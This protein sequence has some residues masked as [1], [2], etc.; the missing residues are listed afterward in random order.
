M[1]ADTPPSL[2]APDALS[3]AHSERAAAYIRE[4]IADAGGSIAFAEFMHHALYAPGLGYYAAGTTKFGEGGD[5]VTAPELSKVFGRVLAR[6]C[7]DVLAGI[8]GAAILEYGAGSGK[9]AADMLEALAG[10]NALPAAYL[11]LEVSADL[12]E[13]QEDYLRRRVPDLVHLVTWIDSLPEGHRG[14]I[15]ANEVLDCLPVERFVRRGDSLMQVRVAMNSHG[16]V[17]TEGPAPENLAQ[18][19]ASIERDIGAPL[20]D[21]YMSEVCLAT[22]PWLGG[23]SSALREGVA[24]LF[25][26]GVS[27]REYYAPDRS[28]GW[29]RCHYR[30]RAHN[31]P[32]VLV[33]IQDMTAW[34]DFSSLANSA[35][36]H[37]F[38]LAGYATQAQFLMGGGLDIELQDIASLPAE[39]RL[40]LSS[41]IKTLTLPGEMGERFKCLALSKGS[42]ASPAAFAQGD[43][44]HTL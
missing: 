39:K 41:E 25:D 5:F 12:R 20:P 23:M 38:D 13:R 33:G 3:A 26:Y 28:E 19:V 43:R 36:A 34:V 9:L 22:G 16:F 40:A 2:P 24:F 44:T 30:H 21:G 8:E 4:H 42:A 1:Q 15:V 17:F 31:D 35:T 10:L 18:T 6:Q 29:L 27:R 11:V 32:L 37:G 7:A 14:V